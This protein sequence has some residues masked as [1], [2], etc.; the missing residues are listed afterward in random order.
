MTPDLDQGS[1]LR[2]QLRILREGQGLI[3]ICVLVTTAAAVGYSLSQDKE[4]LSTAGVLVQPDDLSGSLVGLNQNGNVDPLRQSATD[5]EL[6]EQRT[7]AARVV[8][9]LDLNESPDDLLDR[10][11]GSQQGNS[12]LIAIEVT[13]K[14]PKE[15]ARIA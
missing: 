15:A 1:R 4:Y 5:L 8:R 14:D 10:V 6:V 2:E 13:D 12:S 3:V 9:R 7:L 11:E